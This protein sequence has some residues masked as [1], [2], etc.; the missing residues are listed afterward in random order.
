MAV[1]AWVA[2]ATSGE[3]CIEIPETAPGT[4]SP[5]KATAHAAVDHAEAAT[6]SLSWWPLGQT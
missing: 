5:A 4:S 1:H 6:R 2:S 3:L